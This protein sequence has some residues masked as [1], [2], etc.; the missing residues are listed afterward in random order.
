MVG[1]ADH[2][3]AWNLKFPAGLHQRI[4][5]SSTRLRRRIRIENFFSNYDSAM[6]DDFVTGAVDGAQNGVTP[7]E[8]DVTDIDLY[9]DAAGNAV[10]RSGKDIAHADRCDG[11]DRAGRFGG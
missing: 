2:G 9:F 11:V 6:T 5:R 1:A 3:Q 7:C 4:Y 10:D 8:I